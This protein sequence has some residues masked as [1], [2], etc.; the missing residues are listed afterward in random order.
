VH[1]PLKA[2]L[3]R[4]SAGIAT[5]R[6]PIYILPRDVPVDVEDE[7]LHP[8]VR[9]RDIDAFSIT[10]PKLR[11]LIPYRFE[12]GK[13]HLV[14]LSRYPRAR[15]Y[16]QSHRSTLEKRHCVRVWEKAWYDFHDPMPMD[17]GQL[18]KILVPDVARHN[19]FAY[20][21]GSYWPVHSAYYLVPRGIE[22]D[23]L[24]ALLNSAPIEFL[25][26]LNAPIVKDGFSRYRK[27]FLEGLPIPHTTSRQRASMLRAAKA[28]DREA[29]NRL[30]F[31]LF[32]LAPRDVKELRSFLFSRNATSS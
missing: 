30:A 23:F 13:P 5:G 32:S 2:H 20:D 9:G 11:M 27:Q 15:K 6:D 7:L 24:V 16:L 29:M 3:E 21:T 26:R 14:D 4:L 17:L 1:P 28:R 10:D 25:I 18:P 22:P 12:N 19:R 31:G 8:A